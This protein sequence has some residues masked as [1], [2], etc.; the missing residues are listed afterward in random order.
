[1][2]DDTN[3]AYAADSDSTAPS[4]DSLAAIKH[5]AQQVLD[6]MRD[7]EQAAKRLADAEDALAEIQEK[8]LPD[9]MFEHNVPRFDYVDQATGA[10]YTIKFEQKWRVAMPGRQHAEKRA[11]IYQWLRQIG[12]GGVIKKSI[13]VP[14]GL[15]SDEDAENMVDNLRMQYPGVDPAITDEVAPA[16]LTSLV[17]KLKDSGEN[18][19]ENLSVTQVR[20]AR[21]TEK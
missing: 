21:V 5:L 12:Q 8:K 4:Q 7:V 19:N 10:K 3:A 9:L 2:A 17:S 1:M 16:T 18:V 13:V 14:L 6:R 11:S 20:E 15:K